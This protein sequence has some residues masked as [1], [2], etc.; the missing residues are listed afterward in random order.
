MYLDNRKSL[1]EMCF[2]TIETNTK[3]DIPL[4][5][6]FLKPC[7]TLFCMYLKVTASHGPQHRS[8]AQKIKQP[9]ATIRWQTKYFVQTPTGRGLHRQTACPLPLVWLKLSNETCNYRLS[10]FFFSLFSKDSP[11][12]LIQT[13]NFHI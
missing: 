8:L 12:I 11:I 1:I 10:V 9:G 3:K 5:Y 13:Y 2:L 6:H 7:Y 4:T